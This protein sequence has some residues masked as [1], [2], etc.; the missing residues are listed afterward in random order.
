MRDGAWAQRGQR[1]NGG[2]TDLGAPRAT[3]RTLTFFL[4]EVGA[5]EGFE[6]SSDVVQFTSNE[7][8]LA[9]G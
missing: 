3:V 9:T 5:M 2:G 4:R 6:P 1:G 8:L 7:I